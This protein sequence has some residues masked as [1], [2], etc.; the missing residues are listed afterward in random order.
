MKL[1][2]KISGKALPRL[3]GNGK[4]PGGIPHL[5]TSPRRW[6]WHW[7][8][9]ETCENQWIVHLL[10]EWVSQW[11]WCKYYSDQFG[12]SQRSLLSP[13]GCVK[14]T[15]PTTENWLRKTVYLQ[16]E[17][18][19]EQ[20]GQAWHKLHQQQW[21]EHRHAQV[22]EPVSN[23][24]R[25]RSLRRHTLMMCHMHIMAQG[26]LESHLIHVH[27]HTWAF[28]FDFN[29]TPFLLQP[30]LH[31]PLP[32]LLSH[33]P[34]ASTLSSTTWSPRNTTCAP[35]RTRWV[36]TAYDVHTSLTHN[37]TSSVVCVLIHLTSASHH[38][39]HW[40]NKPS[41]DGSRRAENST[42]DTSSQGSGALGAVLAQSRPIQPC[43]QTSSC[44]HSKSDILFGPRAVIQAQF[45]GK[46]REGLIGGS[47]S[48]GLRQDGRNV[49]DTLAKQGERRSGD[50]ADL[51]RIIHEPTA[52][53]IA[54]GV[55][56]EDDGERSVLI[57][58]RERRHLWRISLDYR[59]LYFWG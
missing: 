15:S 23:A 57:Y 24:L 55:D 50:H 6:T 54:D 37:A 56:E 47:S 19:H 30:D 40:L 7:L 48:Q 58:R 25:A 53:V 35:P 13:T 9:G 49:R 8:N 17:Q 1:I 10:V 34:R 44:G 11:I 29:L 26:V 43:G 14:S 28:L 32:L 18:Q 59:G 39:W 12:N 2:T 5:R 3:G 4:I 41:R 16:P 46:R 27:S 21:H 36:T 38:T 52:A 20:W 33:A 31:R 51:F 22:A 42:H 45:L